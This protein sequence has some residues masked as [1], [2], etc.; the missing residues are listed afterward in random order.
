[1]DLATGSD[2]AMDSARG[3]D[4][5]TGSDSA[6]GWDSAM[7]S[8]MGSPMGSDWAMGSPMGSDWAMGSPMGSD[9]AI[10]QNCST[11]MKGLS[12]TRGYLRKSKKA[13]LA[14]FS[15]KTR[16]SSL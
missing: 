4:S 5:A 7:G 15:A 3:W 2:W 10:A 14:K 12:R 1:M 6:R 16:Q 9:W 11:M 13:P 8:A